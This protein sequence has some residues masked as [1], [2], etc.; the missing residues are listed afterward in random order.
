MADVLQS[1][2]EQSTYINYVTSH[3][4][5]S[6]PDFKNIVHELQYLFDRF[7]YRIIR[8]NPEK[9]FGTIVLC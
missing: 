6:R 7:I 5:K 4:F 2:V 1:M 3:L 8:I 9:Y